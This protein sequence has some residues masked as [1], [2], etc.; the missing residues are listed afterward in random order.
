M[1]EDTANAFDK[2]SN[3]AQQLKHLVDRI[4]FAIT[5]AAVGLLELE[6][7]KDDFA[8]GSIAIHPDATN[9]DGKPTLGSFADFLLREV[10]ERLPELVT[11][12]K[13]DEVR[14]EAMRDAAAQRAR[15]AEAEEMVNGGEEPPAPGGYELRAPGAAKPWANCLPTVAAAYSALDNAAPRYLGLRVL[16]SDTLAEVPRDHADP[17]T[18]TP[19]FPLRP[20]QQRALEQF[21]TADKVRLG[22]LLCFDGGLTVIDHARPIGSKQIEAEGSGETTDV[23]VG[24]S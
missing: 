3:E 2:A 10:L 17:P 8:I 14:Y 12:L 16:R 20:Y 13:A 6:G 24:K 15:E 22:A 21:R 19:L 18:T 4:L 9:S 11:A 1:S 23:K 7:L 5:G